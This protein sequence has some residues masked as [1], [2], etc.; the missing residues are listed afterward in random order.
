MLAMVAP[1]LMQAY[2]DAAA[3]GQALIA[4]QFATCCRWCGVPSGNFWTPSVGGLVLGIGWLLGQDHLRRSA[5]RWCSPLR[6]QLC[7]RIR[8]RRRG[9]GLDLTGRIGGPASEKPGWP[10]R[11]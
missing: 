11:H 7:R 10:S 5:C 6:Q 1:M 2:T 3:A 9:T 8:S 4:S